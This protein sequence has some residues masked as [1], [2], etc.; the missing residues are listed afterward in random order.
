MAEDLQSPT[1][2]DKSKPNSQ[3]PD[4]LFTLPNIPA[5]WTMGSNSKPFSFWLCPCERMQ[6]KDREKQVNFWV[7]SV[8]KFSKL[9]SFP[10]TFLAVYWFACI[11][12]GWNLPF[13]TAFRTCHLIFFFVLKHSVS[14][15]LR[16]T[17][18]KHFLQAPT[19]TTSTLI[20]Q[21]MTFRQSLPISTSTG[22]SW[23]SKYGLLAP[24]EKVGKKKPSFN[25]YR[26]SRQGE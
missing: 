21:C 13:L 15:L 16:L 7:Y 18:Q 4:P 2:K 23:S 9:S 3:M 6:Q 12:F 8:L 17:L 25:H 26:R 1:S 10:V 24:I 22:V 5:K 19:D 20:N 11:V 14:Q